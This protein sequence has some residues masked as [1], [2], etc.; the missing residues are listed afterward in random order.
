MLKSN[1]S[2]LVIGNKGQLGKEFVK[3]LK[4]DYKN[5]R[6]IDYDELDIGNLAS[7]LS[8]FETLKPSFVINCAA[9]TLVDDAEK[10]YCPAFKTNSMGVRNLA[11]A[12]KKYNSFLVHYSTD[13]VFDGKK[14]DGLY[15][16]EDMA[17]PLS[18]YGKSK[19]LGEVF[20]R[21]ETEKF[22]IFRLSW[23]FGQGRQN[24]IYK[25]L[26]WEKKNDFLKI[27][28]DEVSVPTY[29][30]TIVDVTLKALDK[31]L[32]GLYH[33]S[34]S[35]YA[36]RY[37][38]AKFILRTLGKDKLIYPVSKDIFNLPAKR[39]DFAAMSNKKISEKLG[40]EI[41]S[42]EEAVREYVKEY[43]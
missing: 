27:A 43:L 34:S 39:P 40:I 17:N 19:F 22:L 28:S 33:L 18:E 23:V 13:Y 37:E 31:G 16:E 7:V 24:F 15:T 3:R 9:Y 6:G 26:E 12:A 41:I 36:S 4:K 30:K 25:L 11:Y 8:L 32:T 20:L 21:E 5:F 2:Y 29:T 38:W 35:G 42:W 14:T 1:M 10:N